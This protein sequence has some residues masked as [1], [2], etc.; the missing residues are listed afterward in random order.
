MTSKALNK[1]LTL[2]VIKLSI[3]TTSTLLRPLLELGLN[4]LQ[5]RMFLKHFMTWEMF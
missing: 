2:V 3:T 5:K 1:Q 4:V